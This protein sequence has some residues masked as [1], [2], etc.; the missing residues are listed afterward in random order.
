[1]PRIA[2]Y[3]KD[4]QGRFMCPYCNNT[5]SACSGV[6]LHVKS[7]HTVVAP[8][9]ISIETTPT[10]SK[11][12][13]EDD[14]NECIVW[15]GLNAENEIKRVLINGLNA[16]PSCK[17]VIKKNIEQKFNEAKA[18]LHKHTYCT[19]AK[20][21][22]S[23]MCPCCSKVFDRP[24][25][26]LLHMSNN[27]FGKCIRDDNRI[28]FIE[29]TDRYVDMKMKYTSWLKRQTKNKTIEEPTITIE[30]I[31]E[32]IEEIIEETIEEII[33]ETI[34]EPTDVPYDEFL[35]ECCLSID[36]GGY[37]KAFHKLNDVANFSIK[38]TSDGYTKRGQPIAFYQVKD[39]I[40]D[41]LADTF[42]AMCDAWY[43]YKQSDKYNEYNDEFDDDMDY[44]D[45]IAK[46]VNED[47]IDMFLSA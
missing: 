8:Q 43:D 35:V 34:E 3:Q 29:C 7:K 38:K 32:T 2:K 6:S 40:D 1:M 42:N 4:T 24:N 17:Q 15:I 23:F 27:G 25:S 14:D 26:L 21:V 46:Y 31:Q 18:N 39:E 37:A 20:G 44:L 45:A 22:A 36:D 13:E 5:Y 33:E 41:A 19:V 12:L 16:I 10:I 28:S 47:N 9:V 30:P 11:P